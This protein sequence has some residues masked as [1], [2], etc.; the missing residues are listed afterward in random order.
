M[1]GERGKRSEDRREARGERRGRR[2]REKMQ[3]LMSILAARQEYAST[4]SIQND[5]WIHYTTTGVYNGFKWDCEICN[6]TCPGA[7]ADG[8]WYAF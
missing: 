2:G 6:D 4:Y 1:R 3:N 5:P 7:Y 8:I